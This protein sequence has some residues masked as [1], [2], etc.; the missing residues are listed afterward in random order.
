MCCSRYPAKWAEWKNLDQLENTGEEA[1]LVISLEGD[2]ATGILSSSK[3]YESLKAQSFKTMTSNTH[4]K[5]RR[6]FSWFSGKG[7]ET[8]HTAA[9]CQ[10]LYVWL[11]PNDAEEGAMKAWGL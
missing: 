2:A 4:S 1:H 10:G 8:S 11:E 9:R 3:R 6:L 7:K 5:P